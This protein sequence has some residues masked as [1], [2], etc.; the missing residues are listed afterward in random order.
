MGISEELFDDK[1][2]GNSSPERTQIK[3]ETNNRGKFLKATPLSP[4]RRGFKLREGTRGREGGALTWRSGAGHHAVPTDRL[5][6]ELVP[7]EH[8]CAH[9][10]APHGVDRDASEKHLWREAGLSQD[11]DRHP[12][13]ASTP[14]PSPTSLSRHISLQAQ[15]ARARYYQ[16]TGES[17]EHRERLLKTALSLMSTRKHAWF[18]DCK[19]QLHTLCS[20]SQRQALT[21]HCDRCFT[22]RPRRGRL[23]ELTQTV[24]QMAD[25]ESRHSVA[26]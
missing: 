22:G 7:K 21:K 19:L 13:Q 25:A 14:P 15:Y 9:G 11:M 3:Q 17:R 20:G 5:Q 23:G 26:S 6:R 4:Q 2:G 16:L 24:L 10:E 12:S 8:G 1:K 18:W